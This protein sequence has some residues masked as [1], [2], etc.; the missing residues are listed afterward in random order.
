MCAHHTGKTR[1]TLWR[2]FVVFNKG[3]VYWFVGHTAPFL[4]SADLYFPAQEHPSVCRGWEPSKLTGNQVQEGG[5]ANMVLI[6]LKESMAEHLL[7]PNR[8]IWICI[9]KGSQS[10]VLAA[11]EESSCVWRHSVGGDVFQWKHFPHKGRGAHPAAGIYWGVEMLFKFQMASSFHSCHVNRSSSL[12]YIL[13]GV[14]TEPREPALTPRAAFIVPPAAV[15][16]Y[17]T[18]KAALLCCWVKVSKFPPSP[19][20]SLFFWVAACL[21]SWN[22]LFFPHFF[23]LFLTC[24]SKAVIRSDYQTHHIFQMP[25]QEWLKN[26]SDTREGNRKTSGSRTVLIT[27]GS[28]LVQNNRK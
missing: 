11:F 20:N 19:S 5:G 13:S 2:A 6:F 27:A 24:F 15:S 18:L 8:I 25:I 17:G 26:W 1:S 4:S 28:C 3:D 9:K 10:V 16:Q 14:Y 21:T 7:F 22:G 23:L 12:K